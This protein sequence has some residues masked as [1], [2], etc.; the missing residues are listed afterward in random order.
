MLQ[1]CKG[2][3]EKQR[4]DFM[5]RSNLGAPD[6]HICSPCALGDGIHPEYGHEAATPSNEVYTP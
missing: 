3:E 2:Q 4:L 5:V 1:A 6:D